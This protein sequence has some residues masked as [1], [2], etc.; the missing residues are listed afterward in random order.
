MSQQNFGKKCNKKVE[1]DM[2]IN[3]EDLIDS[4]IGGPKKKYSCIQN[5]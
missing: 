4:V 1:T 3:L 5:K 2:K